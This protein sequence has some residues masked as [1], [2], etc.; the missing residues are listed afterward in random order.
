[1]SWLQTTASPPI[2]LR[3]FTEI[4]PSET[5]ADGAWQTTREEALRYKAVTEAVKKQR[6]TGIWSGNILGIEPSK[7]QG[8]KGVGTV[9]QYRRLVQLGVPNEERAL[10]LAGRPLYRLLSRD[11]DPTLLFEYQKEAKDNLELAVWARALMREAAAATLAEAGHREDPRVRGAA[12][13]IV[14]ALSDFLRSDLAEAPLTKRG[15]RTVLTPEAQPP[16]TF[17]V[18][19]VAQMPRLQREWA[20]LIDQLTEFL[21]RPAPGKSYVIPLGRKVLKPT[22]QLLGDPLELERTGRPKDIPFALHWLELL[23]RLGVLGKS[24]SA[25]RALTYLLSECDED[26]IWSP[27]NLRSIPRSPSGLAN[28][29]FPLEVDGRDK[30]RKKVDVTFR[31]C[32]IAKLAGWRLDLT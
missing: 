21:R 10:R 28:F 29:A 6:P 12:D 25:Q 2:R 18:A 26:G 20:G 11:P 1:M 23:T 22:F 5:P 15:T 31:L 3:T 13:R 16:T 27:K 19:M 24:E 8:I 32:L 14:K 4:L 30:D 17:S 9:A 7:S